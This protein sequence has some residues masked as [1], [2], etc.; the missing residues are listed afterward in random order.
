MKSFVFY[1]MQQE[2]TAWDD[3][4]GALKDV[5]AKNKKTGTCLAF[6]LCRT[7]SD[8]KQWVSIIKQV[9]RP[10]KFYN[11]SSDDSF[12]EDAKIMTTALDKIE[13]INYKDE[14]GGCLSGINLYLDGRVIMRRTNANIPIATLYSV[15]EETDCLS[16]YKGQEYTFL[17][18]PNGENLYGFL[19]EKGG[20]YLK[21]KP[22]KP[23]LWSANTK[24]LASEQFELV[25][26]YKLNSTGDVIGE[27]YIGMSKQQLSEELKKPLM[28]Y[29]DFV[30][31]GAQASEYK[32]QEEI[33]K[34]DNE[35]MYKEVTQLRKKYGDRPVD[36]MIKIEP[37]VGMPEGILNDYIGTIKGIKVKLFERVYHPVWN[38]YQICGLLRSLGS[39][40]TVW[41]LNGVVE[42]VYHDGRL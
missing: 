12:R 9:P 11:G 25:A 32:R 3:F 31:L 40:I 24:R 18:N 30:S 5:I 1:A 4:N 15:Q 21:L 7:N 13:P 39:N 27:S 6:M 17:Y 29:E 10:S 41:C 14:Y 42:H 19:Q 38:K 22:V 16:A 26:G 33:N 34:A 36:A 37:Y 2:P 8:P 23:T 28:G 35:Y 20:C